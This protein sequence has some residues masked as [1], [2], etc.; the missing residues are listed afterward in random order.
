MFS[1]N[2]W[3]DDAAGVSA[4]QA[5]ATAGPASAAEAT[6][7]QG[8]STSRLQQPPKTKNVGKKRQLPE[9][10]A[11]TAASPDAAVAR[12][13]ACAAADD[14]AA[15]P[16]DVHITGFVPSVCYWF[17]SCQI[18]IP[19]STTTVMLKMPIVI[20]TQHYK[21]ENMESQP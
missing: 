10:A 15:N 9:G 6:T 4:P 1:Q 20:M 8:A 19:T 11:V 14:N 17:F 5:D 18:L 13:L 12:T 21:D 7:G 2:P 16:A 3:S